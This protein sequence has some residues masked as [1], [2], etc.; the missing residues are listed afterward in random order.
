VSSGCSAT[1]AV[2]KNAAL[3]TTPTNP[4][5][6][7]SGLSAA[8]TYS[9]AVAARDSYGSSAQSPAINVTTLS[10]GT[11]AGVYQITVTGTSHGTAPDAGQSVQVTLV[12]N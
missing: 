11:L 1:Y 10:S 7:V 6:N 9:F 5:S 4:T 12:V 3:L 8:T 2:Y